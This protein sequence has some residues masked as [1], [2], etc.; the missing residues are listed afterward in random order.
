M[1]FLAVLMGKQ[2]QKATNNKPEATS[3]KG[4]G[5]RPA[6][7]YPTAG[8]WLSNIIQTLGGGSPKRDPCN[9]MHYWHGDKRFQPE[10]HF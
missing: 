6:T 4:K 10:T 3:H 7:L 5:K 1:Q 2:G 9:F 8:I